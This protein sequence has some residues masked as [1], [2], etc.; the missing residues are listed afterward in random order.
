MKKINYLI[1][2]AVALS[3][4]SCSQEPVSPIVSKGEGNLNIRLKF[5]ER[6][7]TRAVADFGSGLQANNLHIGIYDA[8][9]GN[10]LVYDVATNFDPMM[11]EDGKLETQ[12]DLNLPTGKTYTLAF[13][14]QSEES[15]VEKVYDFNASSA[16]VTANYSAMTSEGNLNDAYDCYSY[17][18]ERLYMDGTSREISVTMK[19]PVAQ[20]NWGTNDFGA[21]SIKDDNAYGENGKYISTS[22]SAKNAYTNFNL[23][24][25]IYGGEEEVT[26]GGPMGAPSSYGIPFPYVD[27]S[28]PAGN[29]YDYIAMN[30]VLAPIEETTIYDLTLSISN[31]DAYGNG[32]AAHLTTS[33][34]V[35]AAP[36][37]A[38]YRTN[39][40]GNLLTDNVSVDVNK[41]PNW[42]KPDYTEALF[43]TLESIA[44]VAQ[45]GGDIILKGNVTGDGNT[46]YGYNHYYSGL[47]LNGGKFNGNGYTLTVYNPTNQTYQSAIYTNGGTIENLTVN[48]ANRCILAN[49]M[50]KS[51]YV[52][53]CILEGNYAVSIIQQNVVEGLILS[54]NNSILYNDVNYLGGVEAAYFTDCTF[55]IPGS[56]RFVPTVNTEISGCTFP[57]KLA[58]NLSSMREG[59][60]VKFINC[61]VDG[62]ELTADNIE[63]FLRVTLPE[64]TLL[65]DWV[66][67]E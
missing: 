28:D 10:S 61:N 12:V 20:I 19:R 24:S 14:A 27:S 44:Q 25:G 47:F 66:V 22:L 46:E 56:N 38:N 18:L 59:N 45:E 34:L 32:P 11:A 54:V 16:T 5:P 37:Q 41:N 36:I 1:L 6:P 13:F 31:S 15:E 33:V 64:G 42:N 60:K 40:F 48:V 49:E 55:Y 30:Y 50:T 23:L 62:T 35:A 67:F 3:L 26:F 65:S 57:A 53:N 8:D 43:S 52:D 29:A 17:L 21:L 63:S 7:A 39:L 4:V 2:G 9:N 58:L 51:L